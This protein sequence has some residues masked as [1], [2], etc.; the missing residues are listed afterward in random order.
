MNTGAS[1]ASTG[2]YKEIFINFEHNLHHHEDVN[3]NNSS[4]NKISMPFDAKPKGFIFS[5]SKYILFG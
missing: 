1:T 4:T 3:L 2:I 5:N